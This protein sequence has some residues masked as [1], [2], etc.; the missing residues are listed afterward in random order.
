MT[1]H[2][3]KFTAPFCDCA[4]QWEYEYALDYVKIPSTVNYDEDKVFAALAKTP[5]YA[6]KLQLHS[7]YGEPRIPRFAG[8]WFILN[9]LFYEALPV[10]G[11][12]LEW[13]VM[14]EI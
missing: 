7:L 5:M 13:C 12:G 11:G 6:P 2:G 8:D 9:N 10:E 3:R 4:R 14:V 1:V